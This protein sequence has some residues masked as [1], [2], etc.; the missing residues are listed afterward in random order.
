MFDWIGNAGRL[1]IALVAGAIALAAVGFWLGRQVPDL[2]REQQVCA[3]YQQAND[4]ARGDLDQAQIANGGV[5][6]SAGAGPAGPDIAQ[7]IDDL[8]AVRSNS[9]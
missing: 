1:L 5:V 7:A 2:S 8:I 6:P 4:R 3:A 9:C